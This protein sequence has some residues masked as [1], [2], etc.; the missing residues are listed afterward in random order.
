MPIA[1]VGMGG[2]FPNASNIAGYW[3]S[4]LQGKSAIIEV[5]RERWDWRLYYDSDPKALNKTYS[6]IG[7]FVTGFRFNPL[8]FRIPPHVARQMDMVQ[9]LA[10]TATHQALEDAAGAAKSCDPERTAVIFG[11]SMGGAKKDFT[12][13]RVYAVEFESALRSGRV[14]GSLDSAAQSRLIEEMRG[15][16]VMDKETITEDTMPGELSNVIAGRV[17][18]VFNLHGANFTVDA[19]CA[20]SL[21]A[22]DMAVKG[23]R[24]L[25]YDM[26]ICGG[27]DQMMAPPAY[28]KFSK[29]GALSADGSFP[30]DARANGFVMGEGAGVL[31]LKRLDDAMRNG[32]RVY[33]L[34]RGIG[35][36]SDGRGKG[37]TA[38]NT[39]GQKMAVERAF[40]GLDYTPGGVQLVEAHGTATKVGD[41]TEVAVLQEVFGPY[42]Q[43]RQS[44]GLGSV[45]SQIGHL[46]AAAGA[47]GLI[48]TA[49]AIH[50]KILPPSINFETPNPDIDFGNSAFRVVTKAQEWA[51]GN[52]KRR[53]NVSA[54]GFG[55]T[56]FHV[57]L[58][59]FDAARAPRTSA[60][61]KEER[62]QDEPRRMGNVSFKP[63]AVWADTLAWTG[64]NPDGLRNQAGSWPADTLPCVGA[65]L[66]WSKLDPAKPWRAALAAENSVKAREKISAL[67]SALSVGGAALS[68]PALKVKGIFV[69]A[70]ARPARPKIGF[71]FPGQGSQY[72]DMLRDL[73]QKYE[74]VRDTFLEADRVLEPLLKAKLTDILFS[75]EGESEADR[76]RREERIKQTEITQPAVLTA[77]VAL[78]RLLASFGV[79]PDV[80][81]GHSL[82]EY[83]ALVASGIL[84]F[85]DALVAVSA[86]GREMASVK[87]PDPGKMASIAAPMQE[88]EELLKTVP[89]Y[90]VIANKNSPNQTV[91]A[92]ESAAMEKAVALFHQKGFQAQMIP[93]SHA[94]HSAIVAPAEGPYGESLSK[95]KFAAPAIP[96]L[97]NVTADYYP[98]DALG[99]RGLLVRQIS[100]PVEFI[101][102]I[103]RMHA[104]GVRLFVEVGPKRVL[105]ALTSGILEQAADVVVAASNH[106]KR[107]G[108]Y[109]FQE[110]LARIFAEGVDVDWSGKD[111]VK[112][113]GVYTADYSA[114]SR[115]QMEPAA[116]TPRVEQVPAALASHRL[117]S[118]QPQAVISGIA[119]GVPGSWDK[120]FREGALD[121]I[122][123]GQ[124]LIERIPEAEQAKQIGKKIVRLVKSATGDH[125]MEELR[126][127]KDA[128]KLAARAGEFDLSEE[129]GVPEALA[130]SM[131]RTFRLALAAGLSALKDA[132]IPLVEQYR[133][134]SVGGRIPTGW[135]LPEALADETG[136]IFAGAFPGI[137]SLVEEINKFYGAQSEGG[138]EYAF[139]RD[140]L[141]KVLALGH[142]QLAQWIGARGPSACI[143]GACASTTQAVALAEDWIRL[144]RAKRVVVVAGDDIT[145]ENLLEWFASGFLVA[146]AASTE[147]AV[148]RAALPFD[149][150]R[151]GMLIGMGA[152]GLVVEAKEETARRGAHPLVEILAT[153]YAN[154]A[155]HVTRLDVNHVAAVMDK[156]LAK[157]E[158]LWG[159][160]RKDVAKSMLFMSHE[161]YTPARGGSAQAE[162]VALKK[163]FGPD[164]AKVIV[165]NTK[166]FTGHT[167]G[168]SLEDA[169]AIWSLVSGQVPPIANYKEPDPELD[170]ITLSP[171]GAME[172]DYA[173]RLAAGFG[174]QI[175]MTL[176]KKV[177][178]RSTPRIYDAQRHGRWLKEISGFDSPKLEVVHNTLRFASAQN[179]EANKEPAPVVCVAPAAKPAPSV[180]N[181]AARPAVTVA[182]L[183]PATTET[184]S[185]LGGPAKEVRNLRE[186]ILPSEDSAREAVVGLVSEK[187]GYPKEMLELD[188][189]ME[190]DLGIDTVKQAELFGMIRD[191]FQIPRKEGLSLKDYPTIR[192][193][194]GFVLANTQAAERTT[195]VVE[196]EKPAPAQEIKKA[197]P[198]VVQS[199]F[200]RRV[201]VAVSTPPAQTMLRKIDALKPIFVAGAAEPLRRKFAQ[202]LRALGYTVH[203]A[204]DGSSAE[205]AASFG[206]I[207]YLGGLDLN[208]QVL[209]GEALAPLMRLAKSAPDDLVFLFVLTA[210][211]G[212]HGLNRENPAL[213]NPSQGALIGFAKSLA[214]ERPG[215]LVKCLDLAPHLSCEDMAKLAMEEF[216]R[217]DDAV[218]V[219]LDPA[220]WVVET[221]EEPVGPSVSVSWT[222]G[223]TIL[224]T[225]GAQGLG[226]EM[227]KA[228]AGRFRPRL[229][230]LGR[231]ELC[232]ESEAWAA[233]S[234]PQLQELKSGLWNDLK[235]RQGKATP[236]LL[237]REFS[238]VTKSV[239][240]FKNIEALRLSAES[241]EYVRCDVGNESELKKTIDDLSAKY[242]SI[243]CVIHAAGVE[244]SKLLSDKSE[245]SFWRVV[246]TKATSAYHLVRTVPQKPNQVW[247]FLASV[248]GRFGNMGQTDYAAACDYLAKLARRMTV[249]NRTAYAFDLTAFSEVGMAVKASIKSA[250]EA[251]GVEFMPPAVG[252]SMM[253]EDMASGNGGEIVLAGRLGSFEKSRLPAV[254]AAAKT[255]EKK[256][257]V[258]KIF[259]LDED[260][261]LADHRVAGVPYVP[262]VMGMELFAETGAGFYGPGDG[263]LRNVRFDL[264]IKLLR[265]KPVSVR[266]VA[267]KGDAGPVQMRIES[268]FI[269]PSGI[270]LG[271]PREHFHGEFVSGR[272]ES[273]W[274]NLSKPQIPGTPAVLSPEIYSFYFH[275]PRFQVLKSILALG[276]RS[277]L[278]QYQRPGAPLWKDT[279][280]RTLF[281]PMLFEAAFQACGWYDHKVFNKMSL[282]DSLGHAQIYRH[283]EKAKEFYVY[284][285][286]RETDAQG[287]SVFDAFVFDQD[288]NLWAELGQYRMIRL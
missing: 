288:F 243:D 177:W 267:E 280:P 148:S 218:E 111:P 76:A 103:E 42:A 57:A 75:Q 235:A 36:S 260:M 98:S 164:A 269:S 197:S 254:F 23:L 25:D 133:K 29:I 79:K 117:A 251:I 236:M 92:G 38:P 49:L 101:R 284:A 258:S 163:T 10:V 8:E 175:A 277:V 156:L 190:A 195:P 137:N 255:Q 194:I 259:S 199:G 183:K 35:A 14:F 89:G 268:D 146:G 147:G 85:E 266:I 143:N 242:P 213:F 21:A 55:G 26:V 241:V 229:I 128:I 119:A 283:P 159:L 264:P 274:N 54:F 131:D 278:A 256:A 48:K 265:D 212:R 12:D 127:T 109:E 129:F 28:V 27:I 64:D 231:T 192:H 145:N 210:M 155:Y 178:K 225:G 188:L 272:L 88:V 240:V 239:Q 248:A 191:R 217:G 216:S 153:E 286:F 9:Q 172:L 152:V 84:S 244:E 215:V 53:A 176:V 167:M 24:M 72:V 69:K 222:P 105:T 138:R 120:I 90:V 186:K 245:E 65:P 40:K 2:V 171:G 3:D 50:H 91:I 224:I 19:A 82:G 230:L 68:S 99:I 11:N 279:K 144:G 169:V 126:T 250:L 270:K 220:R 281:Y 238:K 257:V 66:L 263:Y 71:L 193:V 185:P 130:D 62:T 112:S 179:S 276:D 97:S 181:Q 45:K 77:D 106:P 219:G 141:V 205:P 81:C 67:Q 113:Q 247:V 166:G 180:V 201:P 60:A 86:R 173:L 160:L 51:A 61:S 232:P 253:L 32:D 223:K 246:D 198:P 162:V 123:R 33:A 118:T 107:G 104:D 161:T 116:I 22:V 208:P 74:T 121:E 13:L 135:R 174:S 16:V 46:K 285:A 206:G 271:A 168:A 52:D 41:K 252:V 234:A 115:S 282:P 249:E 233:M 142:S 262:G 211:D 157:A 4:I 151:H 134:T 58:E 59:E 73:C 83:G 207:F 80:V 273:S 6:K 7:A 237:E 108:V 125:S 136:V 63:D 20:S 202:S 228:L 287:K 43:G 132:G 1:I 102:Q 214:K 39:K 275:G 70:T 95:L 44:I 182:E 184:G 93:V 226:Y 189:D 150:R 114:W 203:A 149:R 78:S 209:P 110:L 37:I 17:A 227:A 30:F 56:N 18:N 204:D 100:S 165:A 122:L 5:P 124:N 15:A 34:I 158:A 154:S 87:V 139:P 196:K 94:F 200:K 47:A 140:F 31:V 221:V 261:Y 170:G 96:I 187:T